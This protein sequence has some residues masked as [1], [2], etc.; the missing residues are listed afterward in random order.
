MNR[1][2]LVWLVIGLVLATAVGLAAT[3]YTHF[4]NLEVLE[5]FHAIGNATFDGAV[6]LSSGALTLTGLTASEAVVTNA[7]KALVS[8]T[9]VSAT[10]VGYLSA[11]TSDIQAQLNAKAP[12]DSPSFTTLVDLAY[13]TASEALVTN[14]SGNIVSATGVSATELGY[15]GDVTSAIQAQLNAKAPIDSPSFTTLL[16]LAY[17]TANEAVATDASGNLVSVAGV[18]DTELGYVGDVTSAIQAQL[19]AKAPIDSPSFTTLLDLAYATASEAVATDASGNLVSV[20][21][22]SDTELGYLGDVTSAIQA[23]INDKAPIDSPAFTT[24]VDLVYATASEAVATDASGNLVSV[25]GVSDTELSYVGDVTSAIQAQLNDKAPLASPSFTGTPLFTEGGEVEDD[26]NFCFGT[27]ANMCCQYDETTDDKFECTGSDWDITASAV[28]VS[29][30]IGTAGGFKMDINNLLSID[31]ANYSMK[32]NSVTGNFEFLTASQS[33]YHTQA[34]VLLGTKDHSDVTEVYGRM[35]TR[36]EADSSDFMDLDFTTENFGELL[37]IAAGIEDDG[38][39]TQ[40]QA[41]QFAAQAKVDYNKSADILRGSESKA[42]CGTG[43]GNEC[44]VITGAYGLAVIK[45]SSAATVDSAQGVR[46]A[47]SGEGG[48]TYTW[49]DGAAGWFEVLSAGT[50]TDGA[51]TRLISTVD[52]DLPFVHYEGSSAADVTANIS[53]QNGDGAASGPQAY[54]SQAGWTFTG[55]VKIRVNGA[56]AWMPYY[57]N[58]PS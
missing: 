49:T 1:K 47:I 21:G 3:E 36:N 34:N 13:A 50:T 54:S 39:R 57:V 38:A 43:T 18:S 15:V 56:E 12:I 28:D 48:G 30:I 26:Q 40:F 19:N 4:T 45:G 17:A 42:T 7:S 51:V 41:A 2:S 8:A 37:R 44:D 46:G 5:L 20:A 58:D 24:L 11:V 52:T 22:V 29:G 16:D 31:N 53:T 9:G 6:S 14:A 27:D 35:T 10:E 32:A 23:Q 55:M 33:G 25:A